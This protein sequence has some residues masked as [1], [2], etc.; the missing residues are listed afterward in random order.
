VDIYREITH[1]KMPA[2]EI[3][4]MLKQPGMMDWIAAPQGTM[5][6]AA[7]MYKVGTLKTMPKAWTDYYL[8]ITAD[9]P[10]N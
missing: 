10:G 3:L 9:L 4:D 2:A 6:F 7:H 5:K 1:D 8:P